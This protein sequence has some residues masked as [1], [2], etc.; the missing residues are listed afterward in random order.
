MFR[1][2]IAHTAMTA[3]A[4]F[5]QHPDDI[6]RL[7]ETAW[8]DRVNPPP[9]NAPF[10]ANA[11][12]LHPAYAVGSLAFGYEHLIYAYMVENTRIYDIFRRAVS[13]LVNGESLD[14]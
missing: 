3:Q 8:R 9:P 6:G 13:E 11:G 4:L 14:I 1:Q 7:V 2:F 10:P 5:Q 12:F